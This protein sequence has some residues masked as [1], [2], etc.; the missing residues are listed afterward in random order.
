MWTHRADATHPTSVDGHLCHVTFWVSSTTYPRFSMVTPQ[1]SKNQH[2]P[3]HHHPPHLP[4]TTIACTLNLNHNNHNHHHPL[5][6]LPH[7]HHHPT[8]PTNNNH[9]N[10]LYHMPLRLL[11]VPTTTTV[12]QQQHHPYQQQHHHHPPPP[13][14]KTM[15]RIN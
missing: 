8:I 15:R 7:Q 4:H 13:P 12:I 14:Y 2:P 10:H 11:T 9:I 6:T 3:P 1:C 5:N